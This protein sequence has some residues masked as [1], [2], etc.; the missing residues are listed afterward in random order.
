M[1]RKCG[2]G[3]APAILVQSFGLIIFALG[4][5]RPGGRAWHEP[6]I[7]RRVAPSRAGDE[8]NCS[9]SDDSLRDVRDQ[10]KIPETVALI[11]FNFAGA[12]RPLS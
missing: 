7:S 12:A 5:R 4:Y 6:V 11:R 1:G 8:R 9:H 10:D 2:E 3:S